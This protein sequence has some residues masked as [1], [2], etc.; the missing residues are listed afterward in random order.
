MASEKSVASVKPTKA[1]RP[2]VQPGGNGPLQK[3]QKYLGEVI[4][5]LKKTTWPTK[6]ELITQTQVVLGVLIGIGVFIAAWD[7]ILSQVLNLVLN[8]LG[9]RR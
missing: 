1:A 7:F 9:I 5:E 6:P 8:V 2:A 3:A 4:T